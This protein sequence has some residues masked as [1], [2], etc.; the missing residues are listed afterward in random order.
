M[1]AACLSNQIGNQGR[2]AIMAIL[3]PAELDRHVPPLDVTRFVQT[4]PE[5]G[6]EMRERRG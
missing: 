2:Q 3:R 4:L 5:R 6:D 1:T